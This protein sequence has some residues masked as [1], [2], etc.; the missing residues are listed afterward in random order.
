MS[1][2]I[3]NLEL[4][5]PGV[6]NQPLLTVPAMDLPEG[7]IYH[8]SGP[9]GTGK[10]LFLKA[11]AGLIP[12]SGFI[13]YKNMERDQFDTQHWRSMISYVGPI[14][15]VF[16]GSIRENILI[17]FNFKINATKPK[18]D[19]ADLR[20]LLDRTGLKRWDPSSPVSKL[21]HGEKVRIQIIR[22]LL[23][24]PQWLLLDEALTNL[25]DENKVR[26]LSILDWEIT[27][28]QVAIIVAQH[29][30]LPEADHLLC[31]MNGKMHGPLSPN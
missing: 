12:A 4:C 6:L 11:L 9:S 29:H 20:E 7:S 16:P 8:L 28:K 3:R 13:R 30:P 10:S 24:D 27:N 2:E 26:V 15:A 21:S 23:L 18:P 31:I 5:P 1:L 25:D 22:H 19:D 17:P 14:P